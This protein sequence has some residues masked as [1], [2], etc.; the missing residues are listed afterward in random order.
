MDPRPTIHCLA[1]WPLEDGEVILSKQDRFTL[2]EAV[3]LHKLGFIV[4]ADPE[5]EA[6]L[7]R[8]EQLQRSQRKKRWIG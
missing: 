2:D 1:A 6:V 5:S 4:L 3:D 7:A 8:W